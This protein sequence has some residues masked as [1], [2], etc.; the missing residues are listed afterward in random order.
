MNM[1]SPSQTI[2]AVYKYE[3]HWETNPHCT[4]TY[5]CV[6]TKDQQILVCDE[7]PANCSYIVH[8]QFINP[9]H[10]YE[11]LLCKPYANC[12]WMVW[13]ANGYQP[14][15]ALVVGSY[16]VHSDILSRLSK[17]C[18]DIFE[19]YFR[20]FQKIL[21]K[22]FSSKIFDNCEN[23]FREFQEVFRKISKIIP[24]HFEKYFGKI[25]KNYEVLRNNLMTR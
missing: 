3:S 2:C 18:S 16:T 10:I 12:T 13:F 17:S 8:I 20:K 25:N 21:F 11:Y 1:L 23:F 7:L 19:K 14:L 5:I 9:V 22:K 15:I 6:Y 24:E 4:Q